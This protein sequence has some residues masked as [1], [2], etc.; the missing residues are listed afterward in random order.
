[1]ESTNLSLSKDGQEDVH[2]GVCA[3]PGHNDQQ[4]A[5]A[6]NCGILDV[7]KGPAGS[8]ESEE[9]KEVDLGEEG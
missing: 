2:N 1:M 9:G 4:R 8:T 6:T 5:H 7:L 3:G